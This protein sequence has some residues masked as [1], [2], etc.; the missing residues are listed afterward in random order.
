MIVD[1]HSPSSNKRRHEG[2][3]GIKEK[4]KKKKTEDQPKSLQKQSPVKRDAH[5]QLKKR[6]PTYN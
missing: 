1:T 2:E 5:K 6:R 3:E 4:K